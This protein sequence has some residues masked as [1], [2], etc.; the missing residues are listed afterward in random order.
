MGFK[1]TSS[2]VQYLTNW[3]QLV[4]SWSVCG[5]GIKCN[6]GEDYKQV[7]HHIFELQEKV[8]YMEDHHSYECNLR[9]VRDSNPQP[10]WHQCSALSTE[11]SGQLGAGQCFQ[12]PVIAFRF[13]SRGHSHPQR[14][15]SFWA[16]PRISTSGKG[17]YSECVYSNCFIFSANQ[18][19]CA[20]WREVSESGTSIVFY[21]PRCCDSWCWPKKHSL[22][23]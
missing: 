9:L 3:S 14:L 22:W 19:A 13:R 18:M 7:I 6:A 12:F 2:V 4:A 15:R 1:P 23:G 21:L 20:E 10:L 5:S 8:Y 11:L 17:Q 16:A